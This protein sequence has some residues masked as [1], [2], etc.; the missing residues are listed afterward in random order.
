MYSTRYYCQISIK[1]EFPRHTFEKFSHIKFHEN[2]SNGSRVVP[3]G[4]TDM[5]KLIVIYRNFGNA[6]NMKV[7]ISGNIFFESVI[8]YDCTKK[9]FC[10]IACLGQ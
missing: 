2:S 9:G 6:P 7:W 3:C 1:F 4:Q 8:Y 5:T 10:Q